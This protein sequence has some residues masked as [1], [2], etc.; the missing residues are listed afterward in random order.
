MRKSYLT[1]KVFMVTTALYAVGNFAYAGTLP[2]DGKVTD[3]TASIYQQGNTLNIDQSTDKAIISWKSFSV[4]K[5]NTVNFN[6]PNRES[7]TLNRVT[8]DFTSEIAGRINANGSVFLVNPNGIMITKHGVV[9]TGNFVASTLDLDNN[10]FLNG[11]YTFTKSGNNGVVTNRG[12][13]FVDDGGFVALLGGAVQNKGTVRAFVGKVGFAGGE[14]IVMSLGDND[15]LRVEVPTDKWQQ[16]TDAD[17]N[18]VAAT[19]DLGGKIDSRGGFIDITVADA[20]D[21]LRQTISIDGIVSANTVSSQH[22]VISISG[23]TLSITGNGRITADADYGNAGTITIDSDS[24]DSGGTVSAVAQSGTGGTVKI[25]LQQGASLNRGTVFDASGKQ[26]GSV[27]FIGGL[28]GDRAYK[29]VGSGDFIA[30]GSDG[31]GGYIDISSKN[32]LVGLFSG[33]VSATGSSRGGRIRIGGAFQGGAYDPKTSALDKKTQDLFGTRWSDTGGLVSAGKTSLGTGVHIDISS[34][35][36]TGGTAILWADHTTNNY[37]SIDATGAVG[38]GAVEVSAKKKVDSFGLKRIEVGNGVILLDPKNVLITRFAGGLSQA[39]RIMSTAPITG[40]QMALND[41]DAF[42]TSV[43]INEYGTRMAVGAPGDDTSENNAGAVY[44]FTIGGKGSRWGA[45]L[46]QQY[47]IGGDNLKL[48]KLDLSDYDKPGSG[49]DSKRYGHADAANGK[50]GSSVAFNADG[51][52]LAVGMPFVDKRVNDCGDYCYGYA[53]YEMT[54]NGWGRVLL[55]SIADKD[56]GSSVT[57][58]AEIETGG[59]GYFGT[60]VALSDDGTKLAVGEIHDE[61]GHRDWYDWVYGDKKHKVNDGWR[62]YEQT[63][64]EDG[65]S[66]SLYTLSGSGNSWGKTNERTKHILNSVGGLKLSGSDEFGYSVALSGDGSTLAVGATGDT[67]GTNY[68]SAGSVIPKSFVGAVY[69]FSVGGSK[70]GETV[71]KTAKIDDTLDWKS[72]GLYLDAHDNFGSSVA[73]SDD[74]KKLAVGTKYD[75]TGGTNKG[76]VYLFTIS[77]NTPKYRNKITS[78]AVSISAVAKFGSAVA[79]SPDGKQLV[80]GAVGEDTGGTDRGAVYL[81]TI[82]WNKNTVSKH[83][84][85][86]HWNKLDLSNYNDDAFGR[87]VAISEDGTKMA[88]G[89]AGDD[90][91]ATNAGA[92]YL[93]RISDTGSKWG[94]SLQQQYKIDNSNVTLDYKK[95]GNPS[96]V[97]NGRFGASVAFNAD[98]TKLVVGMPSVQKYAE[99]YIDPTKDYPYIPYKGVTSGWGRVLLF[100]IGGNDWGTSVTKTAEIEQ[101]GSGYFGFSVALSDDGTKLAV[102]ELGDDGGHK[103]TQKY[104]Q[105]KNTYVKDGGSVSLFTLSGSG[106]SW[107]STNTRTK[108]ILSSVGGLKLSAGDEFGYAVALSGDGTT[109]AVG[110]TGDDTGV[111][112]QSAGNIIPKSTAGAVYLFSVGGSTWGKTVTKTAKID[113]TL[114]WKSNGLY[115]DAYDN[116]GSAVALS[117]DG[118]KLAVGAKYDDDGGTDKGAVYLFTISGNTAKYQEKITSGS[119]SISAAGKF[120]SSVAFNADGTRLAVGATGDGLGGTRQGAVYLLTVDWG[121]KTVSTNR[122]IK[123]TLLHFGGAVALSRD[124]TK[125]AVGAKGYGNKGAVYLFEINNRMGAWGEEVL[126]TS[127]ISSGKGA[128]AL[129]SGA[130]FGDS[131]ALSADGSRLAVGASGSSSRKGAVHLFTVAG[132]RWGSEV[133]PVKKIDTGVSGLSLVAND[134]FG[135]GV[136]FNADGTK[137]AIGARGDSSRGVSSAGAVYLFTVG[138]NTWGDIITKIN[139]IDTRLYGLAPASD[140]GFGYSVALSADA[141]RLAVGSIGADASVSKKNTGAVYLIN[142]PMR[143]GYAW[144]ALVKMS[145]RIADGAGV[146]L[147]VADKFGRGVALSDDGTK[148]AVG[149]EGDDTGHNDSG[150]VYLFTVGGSTWGNTATQTGKIADTRGVFVSDG[151]AFGTAVALTGDGSRLV[152]G[153]PSDDS[154]YVDAGTTHVFSISG[155][156][157]GNKVDHIHKVRDQ[158]GFS[159][160]KWEHFG[161]S[162]ALNG[163]GT[164]MAVGAPLNGTGGTK[165]GAVYLFEVND[166]DGFGKSVHYTARI[167]NSNGVSLSDDDRF[168]ESVA[169]TNDGNTLVVGAIGDD[170]GGAN[171]GAVYV[172][173]ISGNVWGSTVSQS[174]KYHSTTQGEFGRSVAIS[175][176]GSKLAIGSPEDKTKNTDNRGVVRLYSLDNSHNFTLAATYGHGDSVGGGTTLSLGYKEDFGVSVALSGDGSKLAVGALG[177]T[178]N[179]GRK[180]KVYLFTVGTGASWGTTLTQ[181]NKIYHGQGVSLQPYDHFGSAVALNSDGDQ[182]VVGARSDDTGGGERGAMYIFSVS[183]STW[184]KKVVQDRKIAHNAGIVLTEEMEFGTA[185]ALSGDGTKL[186]VGAPKMDGT[187]AD[188]GS[189]Y[190]FTV[191]GSNAVHIERKLKQGTNIKIVASNDITISGDI[192]TTTGAGVLTLIAGRSIIVNKDIKINGGLKMTANTTASIDMTDPSD[193]DYGDDEDLNINDREAGKAQITVATG[194]T[195]SGGGGDLI[196]KML[197]GK[198]GADADKTQTGKITVW[199]ADGQRVSIVYAGSAGNASDSEIVIL[200]GGQIKATGDLAKGAVAIELVADAFTNQSDNTALAI[201]DS[202]GDKGRY[203][204]WTKTPVGNTIGGIPYAFAQFNATYTSGGG[205]FKASPIVHTANISGFIYSADPT[206]YLKLTNKTK[207]YDST[208]DAPTSKDLAFESATVDGLKFKLGGLSGNSKKSIDFHATITGARG[209][210]YDKN[211]AKQE[212]VG[213]DL[214]IKYTTAHT[215]TYKDGN[216]VPVYGLIKSPIIADTPAASITARKIYLHSSELVVANSNLYAGIGM[217]YSGTTALHL[218]TQAGDDGF[219]KFGSKLGDAGDRIVGDDVQLQIAPGAFKLSAADYGARDVMF[220]NVSGITLTGSDGNNYALYLRGNIHGLGG[221]DKKISDIKSADNQRTGRSVI[222]LKRHLILDVNELEFKDRA[223]DGTARA[224]VTVRTNQDGFENTTNDGG[225][226]A[227]DTIT[228]SLNNS[229]AVGKRAFKYKDKYAGDTSKDILIDDAGGFSITGANVKNYTL[230]IRNKAGVLVHPYNNRGE[231]VKNLTSTITKRKLYFE[232][233]DLKA[234]FTGALRNGFD[235]IYDSTTDINFTDGKVGFKTGAVGTDGVMISGDD[236]ALQFQS[237]AFKRDS[238]DY[239]TREALFADVSKI[240]FT[241]ADKD[242][243]ALYLR[244]GVGQLAADTKVSDIKGSDNQNIGKT[245]AV[246]QRVL[247]LDV[248]ELIRK[249][250]AYDGTA[251][252]IVTVNTAAGKDGVSDSTANN[253]GLAA[254]DAVTLN[255]NNSEA[256]G[257]RAFKYADKSVETDKQIFIDD[258][259]AI[260]LTGIKA[261]NYTLKMVL[262]DGT[263]VHANGNTGKAV[264]DLQ[265]SINKRAL[266]VTAATVQSTRVYDDSTAVTLSGRVLKTASGDSG[267]VGSEGS[268]ISFDSI[269]TGSLQGATADANVGNNK[270]VI[271]SG[272]SLKTSGL[273]AAVTDILKNYILV[274]DTSKTTTITPK[275]LTLDPSQFKVTPSPNNSD[276]ANLSLKDGNSWGYNKSDLVKAAHGNLKIR[277][278]NGAAEY[279]DKNPG[280]GKPIRVRDKDK[281]ILEGAVYAGNYALS[282]AGDGSIIANK[283][284]IPAITGTL[285]QFVS[286]SK[287]TD[288]GQSGG[289]SG[290]ISGGGS[291]AMAGVILLGAGAS[292]VLPFGGIATLFSGG[293]IYARLNGIDMWATAHP[294][295]APVSIFNTVPSIQ[296]KYKAKYTTTYDTVFLANNIKAQKVVP[297]YELDEKLYET[298]KEIFVHSKGISDK[299]AGA[300]LADNTPA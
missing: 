26:G 176:D 237:G 54:S 200:N 51:T 78:N 102:G 201:E 251:G 283:Q 11:K 93:F 28:A 271:L 31:S 172:L 253:T 50:F 38:G 164:K 105:Y 47:K 134:Y 217:Y 19:L 155:S 261:K 135:S 276:I 168:G 289:N 86:T 108:H 130:D 249:D 205:D 136:A 246:D 184:G 235:M 139:K 206:L 30:D 163:D 300:K 265:S 29:V 75:D 45:T 67:T 116:F 152:V 52:K 100:A 287:N 244:K 120:G 71:T 144:G 250:R 90:T 95:S 285:T 174:K 279:Y 7:A 131:V 140:D 58:T 33:T 46:Q 281:F 154:S 202:T 209:K 18:K 36:G 193:G 23:G 73:L 56:W 188:E 76:A 4:G 165:R 41:G 189:V 221:T 194:K 3:G 245:I 99:T 186:A 218:A 61:G 70:W 32:G 157:W 169:L 260:T 104:P 37:A 177:D 255:L 113:D 181:T 60:G 230:R 203:L 118:K 146:S 197:T 179:N 277:L 96:D 133:A 233:A 25:A 256:V 85:I 122:T 98:G 173:S 198:S 269:V 5:D 161:Y 121:R 44:L 62:S 204:V 240:T 185:I 268:G 111:Q 143:R 187:F 126:Y 191:Q 288:L 123:N 254:A 207:V 159:L 292:G 101:G 219:G 87:S 149:A 72:N 266:I 124:G 117:D 35:S 40:F 299:T 68:Q 294:Q 127:R 238:A 103:D 10:D 227:G 167:D 110:A 171:Y 212:H 210:F 247:I 1:K 42:G 190:V 267:W 151:D 284:R 55:F 64:V 88:V 234:K 137:L 282:V 232:A 94:S 129:S 114:D 270:P 156:T 21:I 24:L 59:S 91:K 43:A 77:G 79:L 153:A 125:L 106:N 211:G 145:D 264:K 175:G 273:S 213:S 226:L 69:L 81:L 170:T 65:G 248:A 107:G 132:V 17:G 290:G 220:D 222:V 147:N 178:R 66:V 34:T 150:V 229:A 12:A 278:V 92:V 148:L 112:Y 9:D 199:K 216:G 128:G 192:T 49:Y 296:V 258:S 297:L 89:A 13:I 298:I 158:L 195:L 84:I 142:I 80:V 27:S 257:K 180:G 182:L 262:A 115:L 236:L 6:Q 280:A 242:N 208:S 14:K 39:K 82:D 259:N 223:Y 74:G 215:V 231:A 196:I 272:L 48:D 243:Y 97:K 138:G 295:P 225:V 8:G 214:T 162:V 2:S 293:G 83:R 183:G 239:G 109:L 63:F 20:S 274:H 275:I 224:F 15:F 241:G 53:P 22:G 291:G 57:K 166:A 16:L 263:L 252:A 228:L 286:K 160:A 119:V 141:T